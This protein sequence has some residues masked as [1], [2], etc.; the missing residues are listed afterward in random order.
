M[1]RSIFTVSLILIFMATAPSAAR[2]GQFVFNPP[3][4]VKYIETA[5]MTRSKDMAD[6]GKQVDRTE[7]IIDVMMEKNDDGYRLKS[8]L[9]EM[10]FTRNGQIVQEPFL[11]AMLDMTMTYDIGPD[12]NVRDI[13]GLDK[14][15]DKMLANLPELPPSVKNVINEDAMKKKSIVEY[16]G[17]IGD[18]IGREY[19]IGDVWTSESQ[20]TLPDGTSV[21]YMTVIRFTGTADCGQ[22]RCV[23]VEYVYDADPAVLKNFIA[24]VYEDLDPEATLY[25]DQI[26]ATDM[27]ISGSGKRLIDPDTMLIYDEELNRRIEMPMDIPGRGRVPMVMTETRLYEYNY[28]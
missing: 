21:D 10:T 17:R 3:D 15:I 16:N 9:R 8:T 24:D 22:T 18:F 1:S 12:G 7:Q 6:L 27:K 13:I 5:S 20:F 11:D 25:L 14:V 4:G 2:A 28:D 23:R 26:S 19:E